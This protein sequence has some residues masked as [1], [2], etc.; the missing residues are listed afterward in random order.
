[1]KKQ[2]LFLLS[3]LFISNAALALDK[4]IKLEEHGNFKTSE[5]SNFNLSN[6][7]THES[8]V[9]NENSKKVK[10]TVLSVVAQKESFEKSLLNIDPSLKS[11]IDK[12]KN[13]EFPKLA[14]F[15]I[16]AKMMLFLYLL[17][18][19]ASSLQIILLN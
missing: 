2:M 16:K 5:S 6:Y 15:N 7:E 13:S 1:M 17:L 8:F 10:Y 11:K 14:G 3:T 9:L 4:N 19:L 12:N 18:N